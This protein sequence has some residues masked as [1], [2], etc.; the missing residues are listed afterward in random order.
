[1]YKMTFLDNI[2]TRLFTLKSPVIK[3]GTENLMTE[4][5]GYIVCSF[6]EINSLWK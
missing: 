2:F 4:I 6:K 3:S 5:S 1:M